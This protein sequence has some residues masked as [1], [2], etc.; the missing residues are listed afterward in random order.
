MYYKIINFCKFYFLLPLV[1]L[2]SFEIILRLVIF[3]LTLNSNIIIYGINKNI[4]LKLFSITKKEFYIINEAKFLYSTQINKKKNNNQIWIFGGSTSN[5]GF[6]DSKELSWVDLFDT[7]FTK[8]NFAKNGINSGASLELLKY[9]ISESNRPKIIFWTNKVNEILHSKRANTKKESIFYFANS[10]KLTLKENL[11]FI[12]FFDELL[13]RIFDKIGINIRYEK[14]DLGIEDYVYSAEVYFNNTEKAI[15]LSKLY[16]VE[17]FFII[18]LFNKINLKN[19]ETNFY[20]F[21]KRKVEKLKNSYNF[22]YFID[23]KKYLSLDEKKKILFCDNMHQNYDG[24][25]ITAKII[26]NQFNDK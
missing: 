26:S 3:F 18:S 10:L 17:K 25:L 7:K 20:K 16:G 11:V 13:I 12:Y 4:S 15:E 6:C 5:N 1:Y 2:I 8:K 21:Y 24:K 22:V 19:L 9:E 23:T 14:N